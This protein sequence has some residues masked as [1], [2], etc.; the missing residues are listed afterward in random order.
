MENTVELI[1]KEAATLAQHLE[2][3]QGKFEKLHAPRKEKRQAE[4]T[5]AETE[6]IEDARSKAIASL[7]ELKKLLGSLNVPPH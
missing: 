5:E 7:E 6:A 2:D 1:I 4:E 3:L